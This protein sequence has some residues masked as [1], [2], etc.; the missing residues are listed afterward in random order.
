MRCRAVAWRFSG[1]PASERRFPAAFIVMMRLGLRIFLSTSLGGTWNENETVP[2]AP[3]G[4]FASAPLVVVLSQRTTSSL[5]RKKPSR[6]RVVEPSIC[7]PESR[8]TMTAS[9]IGVDRLFC[10][11]MTTFTA[12]PGDTVAL[13]SEE[14]T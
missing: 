1:T 5:E 10:H 8:A 9:V 2:R 7:I 6:E 13:R 4:R 11:E 12:S 3:E 14:H